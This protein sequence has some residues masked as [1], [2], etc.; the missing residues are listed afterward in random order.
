MAAGGNPQRACD[1]YIPVEDDEAT[2][3]L[4]PAKR[5]KYL[6]LESKT[7]CT[8]QGTTG[9]PGMNE[10]RDPFLGFLLSCLKYKP[11]WAPLLEFSPLHRGGVVKVGE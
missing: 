7:D 6:S 3:F 4:L 10:T 5:C 11:S 9:P 2:V 1:T 8:N